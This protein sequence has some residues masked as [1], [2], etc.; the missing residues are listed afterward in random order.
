M[1]DNYISVF[2]PGRLSLIGEHSDWASIYKSINKDICIGSA[3]VVKLND[4]IF[5]KCKISKRIQINYLNE[6]KVELDFDKIDTYINSDDFLKYILSGIRFIKNKFPQI[7][8][9][10]ININKVTLPMK[11]GLGSSAAVILL[12]IHS[13]NLL[14]NLNLTEEEEME[15]AYLSEI[16]IGS[17]CGRLD[18]IGVSKSSVNLLTFNKKTNFENIIIGKD[19]YL[20]FADLNKSKDTLKILNDLNSC[21]PFP[22]NEKE[23]KVHTFLGEKN[24]EYINLAK[25]YIEEG[26]LKSLGKLYTKYQEDVDKYLLPITDALESPY[27][28]KTLN[29]K[30]IKEI[31]LGG[32]GCG[33]F[34]D[35]SVQFL[36]E[37]KNKQT[38]LINYMKEKLNMDARGIVIK[39]NKIKKAIIPIG[40]FGKR[41]YP[42]TKYIGKEF[43]PVIDSKNNIKPAILILLEDLIK[44]GIEEIGIIIPKK[45]QENYK[46]LFICNQN[47]KEFDYEEKMQ[48]IFSKI[49][50]IDDNKQEGVK[51][52]IK[53]AKTFI[54]KDDFILVLG[55][56]I[57]KSY[58]SKN[59][60]EQIL[61]FYYKCNKPVIAAYNTPL[62]KIHKYGV[63]TG[64]KIDKSSFKIEKFT[65]KPSKKLAEESLYTLS[66]KTKK[67]YSVFG[68]YIFKNNFM[69]NTDLEFP[70]MIEKYT[71]ENEVM[72]FEPNGRY[73]DIG[74]VESYYETITDYHKSK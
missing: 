17:K 39:Q 38:M 12:A 5:A 51:E 72:A 22:K 31:T 4:G 30:Y 8:G 13:L 23:K 11:K 19:I 15:Y 52:A 28:H 70:E 43:L 32:K 25:K 26:D 20:V 63:L 18:Q 33:S 44:A 37:D 50:F 40:G 45:Y 71:A 74:N 68:C 42:I 66:N 65:E 3:I 14:Y 6:K 10:T 64:R 55:D 27:L 35:G 61:D 41:M 57:Y 9:I 1:K 7:E 24:R 54:K 67:Y 56:Q 47:Y 46:K 49:T 60:V 48:N 29:D 69:K 2:I 58:S 73:Y 62:E 34:G 53:K 36:V 16:S 21:Y 59:C